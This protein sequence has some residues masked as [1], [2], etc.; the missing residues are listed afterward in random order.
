MGNLEDWYDDMKGWCKVVLDRLFKEERATKIL[1]P[2][3]KEVL[4]ETKYTLEI[5]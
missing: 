5:K 4:E 3:P 2:N 1:V